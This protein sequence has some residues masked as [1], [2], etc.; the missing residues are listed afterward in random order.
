MSG[1]PT[2]PAGNHLQHEVHSIIQRHLEAKT[3]QAGNWHVAC[4]FFPR[5]LAMLDAAV[6]PPTCQG[7]REPWTGRQRFILTV[8]TKEGQVNLPIY[9][10]VSAPAMAIAVAIRQISRGAMITAADVELQKVGAV[11]AGARRA[12]ITSLEQLIGMEARQAIQAGEIVLSDKVQAPLLVKRGDIVT[13][14]SQ[15]GGIRV[16]TTARAR[17]DGAKGE[18][19]QVESLE[20]RQPYDARV[21][22]H[23]EA[24]VFVA[25][26]VTPAPHRTQQI[27]TARR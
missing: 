18:L 6:A 23:R 16:R 24:A 20:T 25:A 15:S 7:G 26:R 12:P 11:P 8:P 22:G 1:Q 14:V 27:E 17:Q 5:E 10:D 19:V 3:G 9:A 4:K 21:T 2:E 13:V